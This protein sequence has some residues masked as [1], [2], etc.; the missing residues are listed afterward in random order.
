LGKAYRLLDIRSPTEDSMS[1]LANILREFGLTV[2]E[3]G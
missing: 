1:R 3:E 2:N